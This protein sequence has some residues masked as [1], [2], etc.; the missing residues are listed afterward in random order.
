MNI[1]WN[2][3]MQGYADEL[4]KTAGI[5]GDTW[6]KV[7]TPLGQ[8]VDKIKNVVGQGIDKVKSFVQQPINAVKDKMTDT[9]NNSLPGQVQ[10]GLDNLG[11]IASSIA[12]LGLAA[13]MGG[14]MMGGGGGQQGQTTN[15]YYGNQGSRPTIF[16][17]SKASVG[18][19]SSP[20]I[21]I[22]GLVDTVAGVVRNRAINNLIDKSV[23]SEDQSEGTPEAAEKEVEITSKYPEMS[24]LLEDEQNKAYLQKLLKT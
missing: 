13:M 23:A 4:D 21:K 10:S 6:N 8:G 9:Y 16:N 24:K 14:G 2:Q 11:N 1:D 19:L 20:S 5:A 15:N 3:T 22:S 18:S 7:K 17:Q 12:P